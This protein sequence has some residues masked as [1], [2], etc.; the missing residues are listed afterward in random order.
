MSFGEFH[1]SGKGEVYSYTTI[2]QRDDAPE[3]FG[4]MTPYTVALVRLDEGPLVTAMMTDLDFQKPRVAVRPEDQRVYIGQRVE[5]V[6]RRL[7]E[8]EGRGG[9]RKKGIIVYGYHA[10]PELIPAP[11]DFSFDPFATS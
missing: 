9:D 1:L 10:R 8:D 6:T 4:N 7:F 2:F 3:G 11:K 5:A